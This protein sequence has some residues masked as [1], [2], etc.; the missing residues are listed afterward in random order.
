MIVPASHRL[1]AVV[2][3]LLLM[4]A[5]AAADE[6]ERTAPHRNIL[7]IVADDLGYSDLGSYGSEIRTPNLDA[8]AAEGMRFTNFNAPALCTPSRTALLTSVDNHLAGFGNM[9]GDT[10]PLQKGRPGYEE[11]LN[12]RVVT[13]AEVLRDAGY[14]TV[15]TGKWDL[16]PLFETGPDRRGFERSFVLMQGAAD[17]FQQLPALE[18]VPTPFYRENG[19]PV[20]LPVDHYSSRTYADKLLEYV[21]EVPVGQPFFAVLAFTAPHWPLQAPDAYLEKYRGAYRD[22]YAPVRTARFNKQR[23]LGIVA[24]DLQP[25]P[26]EGPW[27]AWE[28]LSPTMRDL[29]SRRMQVYA[30]MVEAL[31]HEVGRV[32]DHLRATGRLDDTFILFLSDNGAAADNP[33]DWGWYP[34]A[35]RIFDFRPENMGRRGSYVWYGPGWAHVSST[36]WRL[37]K[38]FPTNGGMLVPAIAFDR[39]H[40][41]ANSISRS[42][43]TMLDVTPTL[44][45]IAD[46]KHPGHEYRGRQVLPMQGRSFADTLVDP[47]RVVHGDGEV[48]GFEIWNRRA[49]IQGDWKIVSMNKP[50][51]PGLAQWSLF[52]LRQDPVELSDLASR[53]PG[54]LAQMVAHWDEYVQRNGVI[55]LDFFDVPLNNRFTHYEWLPPTLRDTPPGSFT[56]PP[57]TIPMPPG[58]ESP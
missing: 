7:V 49:V 9:R 11:Q 42:R 21:D 47:R 39:H 22:G 33:L 35:E 6:R 18:E 25:A 16:G 56:T 54:K 58:G 1:L 28:Q 38:G 29:E 32:V 40:V 13:V 43:V 12:D 19:Q 53:E 26:L 57:W 31:D 2:T 48:L 46:V 27:P 45:A 34:W 50:W 52:N 10:H 3:S 15:I 44:L 51:G 24:S 8:L 4:V 14:H 30:A 17:H 20:A 55:V 37:G 36:P 5:V 23:E 41:K